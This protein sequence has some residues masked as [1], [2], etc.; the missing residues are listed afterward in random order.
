MTT[1]AMRQPTL[2]TLGLGGVLDILR[3]GR[4]PA[5]AGALVER[6]FGAPGRRG[7]LVISGANGIV[8]AGKTMQ[9]GS[10]LQPFDVR[11][12]ALDFPNA[13]DGIGA[14]YPGLVQAFG[15]DG[16]ARIMADVVRLS[17]DGTHL[18]AELASLKPRFLLEAIP[19]ILEVKRAHYAV[20]RQAFPDIAIRSVTSGFPSSA[21]GVGIAHPAFPHQIN[22]VWEIVEPEPSP[23]T[24]LLWALGLLPVP[25]SDHWS[26]VLDVLFCGITLAA[27]RYHHARNMPFWKIDK[28]ARRLVGPNPFRAHDAIGAKGASFLTWSCLHH[29][30]EHYG[31]LFRP[32]P[33]LVSHKDSG[34]NW[35]PP[36]HFRPLVNW[37]LEGDD[38]EE[39]RTWILGPVFQMTSLMLHERRAHLAHLNAIGE[40][41]AQFRRGVLALMREAG[42][43]GVIRTVERYHRLHPEAAT[44]AWFPDALAGMDAP[45][46]CQLYVNAEHDGTVGVV[47]ISRE[48]YNRDVDA[49]LNRALDWLKAAKVGRVIVTG[50]FHL[51][52]QM[53]GADTAEFYPALEREEEGERIAGTWSRTARRLHEEFAVS[54]GLVAGK[55]ALGGMLELLTHCHYVV[56]VDGAQL[57]MPEVTL[58][59]APGMEGCHWP[60]R[61]AKPADRPRLL[62]LLLTG[63]PV[64]APDAVGWLI[65][66]AGPLDDA[67]ATAWKVASDGKHGLARRTLEA[68]RLDV[69]TDVS[70]LPP[71]GTPEREAGRAAVM[72]CIQR[73]CAVP[74]AEALG[75]QAR[76]S[77]A[78]MTSAACRSGVVGADYSKTVLV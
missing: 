33:E 44:S 18:P 54:V 25:V 32:T 61:K 46:W 23:V 1:T 29:L 17:Y 7:S 21:L 39:F 28:F 66:Y 36:D 14:Q 12:A 19:E 35:Y 8:G 53:V 71:A 77:A 50:D 58:P 13:P 45:E 2:Q 3:N 27:L 57:G 69:P 70:G 52:T 26:F 41:C 5:D 47:T 51:S 20:F 15:A 22:K 59:V 62:Q 16:A 68:G 72:E 31:E 34:Q 67:L 40:L 4:L 38:E 42:P 24:Q 10:R 56:A 74:L 55:R 78:F 11:I 60:L 65:D 64:R 30:T 49:E 48:S 73:S 76:L 43:D 6:V 63:K 75:V 37:T 9:L